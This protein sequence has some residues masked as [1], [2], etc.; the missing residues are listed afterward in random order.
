[1]RF[2]PLFPMGLFILCAL[3]FSGL[4][5]KAD[6]QRYRFEKARWQHAMQTKKTASKRRIKKIIAPLSVPESIAFITHGFNESHLTLNRLAV[7]GNSFYRCE[8]SGDFSAWMNWLQFA[9]GSIELARYEIK[10][11]ADHLALVVILRPL[12][13]N[14][15]HGLAST[16]W[17]D[18][19]HLQM[20]VNLH[21]PSRQF[22]IHDMHWVGMA[23]ANFIWQLPN[24]VLFATAPYAVFGKEACQSHLAARKELLI[25]CRALHHTLV[26]RI[27]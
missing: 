27:T 11:T 16:V 22:S 3:L 6:W 12:T 14:S 8:V 26:Q 7:M 1:M 19:F 18:P 20:T 21:S 15:A 23:G 5:L 4:Y 17:Q 9:S 10:R 2:S 13:L 25:A 24:G